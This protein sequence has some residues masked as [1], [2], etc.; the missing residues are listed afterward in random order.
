MLGETMEGS[1]MGLLLIKIMLTYS[2]LSGSFRKH[3]IRWLNP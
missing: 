3:S 1:E 2:R